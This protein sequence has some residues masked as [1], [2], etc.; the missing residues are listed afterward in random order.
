L[1]QKRFLFDICHPAEVHHFKHLYAELLQNHW[2]VLFAAKRK[3]VSEELLREYNLPYVIFS[4]NQT[5]LWRKVIHLPVSCV[6][7]I[8]SFANSSLPSSS[9]TFQCTAA[10]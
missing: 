1:L 10:G 5:G 3:D 9:A 4:Y 8:R 2:E 6:N 7:F